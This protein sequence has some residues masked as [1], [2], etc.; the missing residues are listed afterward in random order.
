MV[1]QDRYLACSFHPELTDDDRIHR[2][3]IEEVAKN[4]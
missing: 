3:F 2:Y 4:D 1:R